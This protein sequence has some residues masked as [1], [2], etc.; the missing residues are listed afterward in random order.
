MKDCFL[1]AEIRK[2]IEENIC[3][4]FYFKSKQ[5]TDAGKY[6]KWQNLIYESRR[7]EKQKF[8]SRR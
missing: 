2:R 6:L 7:K 8:R 4:S 5:G 1:E 3:S